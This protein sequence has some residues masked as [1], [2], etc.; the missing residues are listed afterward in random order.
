[1]GAVKLAIPGNWIIK[2]NI[3][4]FMGA[5]TDYRKPAALYQQ[6]SKTVTF[7]GSVSLG[8][9]ELVTEL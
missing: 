5:I 8:A 4:T 9:L 3:T 2:N 7:K 1:M 6:A